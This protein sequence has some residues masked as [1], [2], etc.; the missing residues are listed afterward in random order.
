LHWE[1]RGSIQHEAK[2]PWV[3]ECRKPLWSFPTVRCSHMDPG[4]EE[5]MGLPTPPMKNRKKAIRKG[6]EKFLC[7]FA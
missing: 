7:R 2:S 3:E 1:L 5:A 6:E 4:A